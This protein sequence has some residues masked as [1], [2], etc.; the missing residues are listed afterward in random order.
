MTRNEGLE[1]QF[2]ARYN[3]SV[4]IHSQVELEGI[5]FRRSLVQIT[6]RGN[7]FIVDERLENGMT[8]EVTVQFA[9]KVNKFKTHLEA[10]IFVAD[11]IGEL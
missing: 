11:K 10:E 7:H 6:Y 8:K 4:I 1:R 3:R 2:K 5:E 9:G